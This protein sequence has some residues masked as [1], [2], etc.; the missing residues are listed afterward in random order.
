MKRSSNPGQDV[1]KRPRYSAK[2][3]PEWSKDF[4][5]II[6]KSSKGESHAF[7]TLCSVDFTV[8]H[9]GKNDVQRHTETTNHQARARQAKGTRQLNF[10][11][12]NKQ[13]SINAVNAEVLFTNFISQHNLPFAVSDHFT[14]IVKQMFPDSEIAKKYACGRTKTTQIL[15]G[16]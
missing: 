5:G 16:M 12:N 6:R 1:K 7:C 8:S 3:K 4:D 2:F 14:K 11:P 13:D 15:K 9:G 10:C